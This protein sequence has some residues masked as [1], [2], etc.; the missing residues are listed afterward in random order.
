MLPHIKKILYATDLSESAKYAMTWAMSLAE[1]YDA[2]ITTLHVMPDLVEE[3]S[4][5]MGY[6]LTAH[7]GAEK[8]ESFNKEGISAARE[9]VVNRIKNVSQE[10]KDELPSCRLD[11]NHIIIKTGHPVHEILS[12]VNEG[13]YDLVV[14]GSH[15]H[16]FFDTLLL[17]SVARGVVQKCPKP[18]LTIRLPG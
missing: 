8:L 6:D 2:A 18:V 14:M 13:G 10:T 4:G 17:G 12:A 15:G 11:L 7:F 16:G 3:M 9:S 1:K 5:Q